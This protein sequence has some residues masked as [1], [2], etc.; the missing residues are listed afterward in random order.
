MGVYGENKLVENGISVY[1]NATAGMDA[2]EF[3]KYLT[4]SI[5]PL[6]PN[7]SD[8]YGKRVLLIVDSGPGRKDAE[9]LAY[10]RARGFLLHPGV[11]NTTHVTQPT[12]QNYGYFK[13]LY[14]KNLQKLVVYR[15]S[16]K[17]TVGQN[18]FPLLVFGNQENR[19]EDVPLE[20]AFEKAFAVERSKG[21][22]EKIKI[23]PFTRRC[24]QDS[25]VAHDLI[26]RNNGSI[27][28]DA[29]PIAVKLVLYEKMNGEAIKVL[30]DGCFYGEVFRKYA[31]RKPAAITPL[32]VANTR[33]P[34]D[35]IAGVRY[36]SQH[37]VVTK[38]DTLNTKDYFF[39]QE[40]QRRN[41]EIKHLED[42]KKK[43]KVI[44]NLN[45]KALGLIE[46]FASKGKEVYKEEDA[47]FLPVTTLKVLCQWKQQPKIPSRKDMLLNMWMQV[48]N[49]P[50][51][52]PSWSPVD[53]ALLEK[54]KTD[55]IT[56]ADTALGREKL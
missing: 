52:I 20:K 43:P 50:S 40:R 56:I 46:E 6:Y 29:D 38:G 49:V 23:S 1:C 31:P 7:A 51:P 32:T 45:A 15:Q 8:V 41:D 54:L 42:A 30:N 25:N 13:I 26:L 47:K 24:L 2:A 17:E 53:E 18:D 48:K 37:F 9:L 14:Q 21:Y 55:E 22:W 3:K 16:K 19:Y 33:A 44:A 10:L 28:L 5:V 4:D 35:A 27:D 34:Q 12:D 36:S 11:P 39:A